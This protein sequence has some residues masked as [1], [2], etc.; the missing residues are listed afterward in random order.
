[1][2][3]RRAAFGTEFHFD[4]LFLVGVGGDCLRGFSQPGMFA[5]LFS[6]IEEP[7]QQAERERQKR[8]SP[9]VMG[10]PKSADFW[11]HPAGFLK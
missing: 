7:V 9:E 8:N 2:F 10:I 3:E 1:F 4:L 5:V 6:F 11:S